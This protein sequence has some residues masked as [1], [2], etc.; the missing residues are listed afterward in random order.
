MGSWEIIL[1]GGSK[2][3]SEGNDSEIVIESRNAVLR[4]TKSESVLIYALYLSF[5]K[6]TRRLL[7][8]SRSTY[9]QVSI[10][11]PSPVNNHEQHVTYSAIR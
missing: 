7:S 1:F 3:C 8:S 2:F 4:K 10:R 11:G 6:S 9:P 5:P